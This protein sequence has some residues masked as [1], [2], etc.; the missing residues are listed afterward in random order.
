MGDRLPLEKPPVSGTHRAL[1]AA[2]RILQATPLDAPRTYAWHPEAWAMRDTTGEIRFAEMWLGNT[3]SR[4]RLFAAY[5]PT[6]DAEPVALDNGMAVELVARFAGGVG[7]QSAL[8]RAFAAHLLTPGVGYLVGIPALAAA[9]RWTVHSA[10]E[11]RLSTAS[12]PRFPGVAL[13]D[14]RR[15]EGAQ[16]WEQMPPGTLAVKTHRPHPRFA[17][18]PD[19]PVRGALPILRELSLLTQH[20]EAMATSRLAGAGILAMD[21]G[22]TFPGGW[23]KWVEEFLDATTKPIRDRMLAGAYVPFP[24]RVPVGKGQKVADKIH[25]LMFNTPFDEHSMKLRGEAL[26]RLATAMDMPAKILTGESSNHWGDWHVDEQGITIHAEPNLEL[27]CDALTVGYLQP[28]LRGAERLAA[29]EPADN[30]VQLRQAPPP[31]DPAEPQII[32]WYDTSELRSEPDQSGDAFELYDRGELDG[33]GLRSK[34]VRD[35]QAPTGDELARQVWWKM[36][37]SGD[38]ALQRRA[39]VELGVLP[40]GDDLA[41]PPAAPVVVTPPASPEPAAEPDDD[42]G[43]GPPDTRGDPPPR[44]INPPN[45]SGP[46]TPAV[47]V[48][49]A[50]AL[51]AAADGLVFRALERAGNRL[52]SATSRQRTSDNDCAAAVM[53]TCCNA[54]LVRNVDQLLDGA[55][56][57]LP[58]VAARL[59]EPPEALQAALDRYVRVLIRTRTPHS[60]ETLAVALG[61]DGEL[62]A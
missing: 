47:A 52:R 39:M 62:A 40:A 25:H 58:E 4:C 3:L 32:V 43:Q 10:D 48:V 5:R 34:T 16:D 31:R 35:G 22:I 55:W 15:G 14:V 54:G 29:G 12:D 33:D 57:R 17:W 30:V 8:L 23:E 44:R 49:S 51:M 26:D 27:I 19:S 45:P 37:D 21:N 20:V 1:T 53:H 38:P 6:P 41:D 9:D 7:G 46:A 59:G 61:V 24:V 13:W 56:D 60:W 2:A 42:G 11:V 36:L 50:A 18:E 28:A